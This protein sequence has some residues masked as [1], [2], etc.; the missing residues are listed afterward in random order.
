MQRRQLI[1]LTFALGLLGG[2]ALATGLYTA[3]ATEPIAHDSSGG[4]RS[5]GARIV[6]GSHQAPAPGHWIVT[7]SGTLRWVVDGDGSGGAPDNKWLADRRKAID[8]VW[9]ELDC[10]IYLCESR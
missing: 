7:D 3:T 9:R 4:A 6:G 5:G 8:E 2:S 1:A 10:Q